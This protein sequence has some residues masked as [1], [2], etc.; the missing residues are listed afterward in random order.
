MEHKNTLTLFLRELA[1]LVERD[2]INGSQLRCIGEFYMSYLFKEEVRRDNYG[3]NGTSRTNGTSLT[4][5]TSLTSR[6]SRT[7]RT[8]GTRSCKHG[9]S[10]SKKE[11]Q[12][13]I[14]L[15]W[16]VYNKILNNESL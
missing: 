12:K 16:Y 7:S 15:G 2:K 9:S 5:L 6:T 3:T 11:M 4:S 8:N 14:F 13:F 1:D 10:H